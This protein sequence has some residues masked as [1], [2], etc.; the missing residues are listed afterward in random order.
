MSM[1]I[2][3]GLDSAIIAPMDKPMM[4]TIMTVEA[5]GG[6]DNLRMNFLKAYRGRML[7]ANLIL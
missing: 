7:E 3:K 5:L 1:A 4:V 2:A 6:R